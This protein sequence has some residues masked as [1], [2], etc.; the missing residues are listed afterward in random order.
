MTTSADNRQ[1][2]SRYSIRSW[3]GCLCRL[4]SRCAECFR[5]RPCQRCVNMRNSFRVVWD[6]LVMGTS[7][8]NGEEMTLTDKRIADDYPS[9][10]MPG[11]ALANQRPAHSSEESTMARE[12]LRST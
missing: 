11:N 3:H 4:L 2:S 1:R 8:M 10:S 7:P 5:L 6:L 12:F 9:R